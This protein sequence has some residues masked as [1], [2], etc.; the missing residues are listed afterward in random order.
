LR[1]AATRPRAAVALAAAFVLAYAGATAARAF[2]W[3][4]ART[5]YEHA[6]QTSPDSVR[7]RALVAYDAMRAGEA[8]LALEHLREARP[9]AVGSQRAAI[10]LWEMLAYCYAGK[11]PPPAVYDAF[12]RNATGRIDPVTQRAFELLSRQVEP[13]D[14]PVVDAPR[15]VR[16]GLAWT[17]AAPNPP[18]DQ[19]LWGSRLYLAR[20]VAARGDLAGAATIAERIFADS[21]WNMA[22]G[23]FAFQLRAS[24]EDVD[25]QRRIVAR[26]REHLP[27]GDLAARR[28]VEQLEQHVA[29]GGAETPKP[30]G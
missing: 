3:G 23:V 17:D 21:G 19:A 13:G 24:L 26:L 30:G 2:V 20:I 12:E 6:L 9:H 25:A 14:C 16:A 10:E 18:H 29:S 5:L 7:L 11:S 27:Y 28:A 22:A 4:D 15:V 8:E 1:L